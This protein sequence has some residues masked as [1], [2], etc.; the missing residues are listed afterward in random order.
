MSAN[1]KV[2]KR[3]GSVVE[4]QKPSYGFKLA[5]E[6]LQEIEERLSQ[7]RIEAIVRRIEDLGRDKLPVEEIQDLV[8]QGLVN[9][10]KFYLAKTYIIYRYTRALVRK[11]NTTDESIL[12]LLRNENKELAE[13]YA[14]NLSLFLEL[15]YIRMD[16]DSNVWKDYESKKNNFKWDNCC[17]PLLLSVNTVGECIPGSLQRSEK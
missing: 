5:V 13:D 10:N 17:F 12:S 6:L 1:M 11:Q 3:D 15:G 7:D 16:L 2:I 4:Y 8:E 9:E 14:Q